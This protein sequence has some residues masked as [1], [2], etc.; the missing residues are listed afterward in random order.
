MVR[1]MLKRVLVLI[2]LALVVGVFL[3]IIEGSNVVNSLATAVQSQQSGF[4]GAYN[5][6]LPAAGTMYGGSGSGGSCLGTSGNFATMLKFDFDWDQTRINQFVNRKWQHDTTD[7]LCNDHYI[8]QLAITLPLSQ[9]ISTLQWPS[10]LVQSQW[11]S[12][13]IALQPIQDFDPRTLQAQQNQQ[14]GTPT[15]N[16]TPTTGGKGKVYGGTGSGGSCLGTSGTVAT[17]LIFDFGWDQQTLRAAVNSAWLSD[18]K[19]SLC[20]DN[21]FWE[22]TTALPAQQVIQQLQWPANL[23]NPQYQSQIITLKPL[24][25]FDSKTVKAQQAAQQGSDQPTGPCDWVVHILWGVV[26]IDLC[27]P[28][29]LLV[30]A[31]NAA[32]QKIYQAASSQL[33]FLSTTPTQPFT[34]NK[35]GGLVAIWDISW[36]IVLA[37]IV[38]VVAWA[39]LRYMLGSTINWLAYA[40][41]MEMIPRLALGLLAAL[42]SK[43]IFLM[44]IEA[45]N[46]LVAIFECN[47]AAAVTEC[48]SSVVSSVVNAHTT[49]TAAE[50]LQIVYGI[51]GFLLI[52]EEAARIAVIY[53]LFA[54][55]PI[56]FFLVSLRETER[57]AKAAVL[58]TVLFILLQAMQA[59]TLTVGEQVLSSVLHNNVSQLEFLNL[60]VSIAILY[61]TLLLFFSITRIAFGFAGGP[62]ALLP[63]EIQS[64]L[65]GASGRAL[66]GGALL[67]GGAARR[68]AGQALGGRGRST[69]RTGR[70]QGGSG[71]SGQRGPGGNPGGGQGGPGGGGLTPAA[72][73]FSKGQNAP[74]AGSAQAGTR[75]AQAGA[76]SGATSTVPVSSGGQ[77]AA[78][79]SITPVRNPARAVPRSG[80][81]PAQPSVRAGGQRPTSNTQQGPATSQ[82]SSK[83][84]PRTL[85]PTRTT[86]PQPPSS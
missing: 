63:F 5:T 19:D 11:T 32:I 65:V 84:A 59:G 55:S 47:N 31:T 76:R 54:F 49:G 60:L 1:W 12:H 45:N 4:G 86:N 35:A 62:L 39:S 17:M 56:L 78:K 21:Y 7:Q 43:Q 36:G 18:T 40:N 80:S 85:P 27:A 2:L 9:I 75:P 6:N 51:M 70:G 28:L 74:A 13:Y 71:S 23:L 82:P 25:T 30:Q 67:A 14:N 8:W 61:I 69:G 52:I 44:L 79:S 38:A 57:W 72:P 58:A 20:N 73:L 34:D 33:A 68:I 42:F 77:G 29:R 83:Q 48:A 46:A 16:Q 64:G 53:L 81:G 41:L 37:C 15:P 50:V 10:D 3:L 22:T 66:I 24:S 26:H